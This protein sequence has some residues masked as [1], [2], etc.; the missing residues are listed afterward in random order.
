M[1]L[2]FVQITWLVRVTVMYKV[3]FC[4][5]AQHLSSKMSSLFQLKYTLD[6]KDEPSWESDRLQQ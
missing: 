2:R 3:Q 4:L 5:F 6:S 1:V